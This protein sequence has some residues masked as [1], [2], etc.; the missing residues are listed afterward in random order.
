MR[1]VISVETPFH[2]ALLANSIARNK[3]PLEIYGSA[4]RRSYKGL[5]SSVRT[6]VVPAPLQIASHLF[7]STIPPKLGRVETCLFDKAV[8]AVMGSPDI[9]IGW[10]SQALYAARAAKKR[11]G[12]F[13]L[14]RACPHRDF[15]ESLVERESERLGVPYRPQ[16]Q[17]FRDRQLEEYEIADAILVPS[18]YSVRTF[19]EPLRHKLVKAPLLGRCVEPES[20]RKEPNAVFTVGVLGGSPIRKG[21]LYLLKA[22]RKLALPNAKLLIRSG[23]LMQF[24]VLRDLLQSTPNVELLDYI[25]NISDFYQRCDVFVLPSVDDGFGMALLEAML[26]GRA[27]VATANT[28]ASELMTNGKHGIVVDAADE[29]QL[30][31]AIGFLYKDNDLRAEMGANAAIRAREIAAS[32]MYDEA[33]S[34]LLQK[35]M[36]KH[37]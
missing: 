30:A 37:G 6:H 18:E 31:Q 4:P 14:D 29:D 10:A 26:N 33:I 35:L 24:P 34:S 2:S 11:G 9:F 7:R 25:P 20:I 13:V 19:S 22:W 5:N 27:C 23:N 21:Y 8:S 15:Q 16:P 32:G 3:I 28:G 17:W 36:P 12:L 1:A